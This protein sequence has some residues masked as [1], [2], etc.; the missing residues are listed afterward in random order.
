MR[1]VYFQP[2]GM[3]CSFSPFSLSYGRA[4]CLRVVVLYCSESLK[5]HHLKIFCQMAYIS[6][7]QGELQ[8]GK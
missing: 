4:L 7:S 8:L 5:I 6:A 1:V 2:D 3:C